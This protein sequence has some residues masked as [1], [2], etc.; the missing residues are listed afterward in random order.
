MERRNRDRGERPGASWSTWL[1]VAV[2]LAMFYVWLI[3][4]MPKPEPEPGPIGTDQDE[5]ELE[6]SPGQNQMAGF[7]LRPDHHP[8]SFIVD[9]ERLKITTAKYPDSLYARLRLAH[10]Y[11]FNNKFA[12]AEELYRE[13]IDQGKAD[14]TVMT[15]YGAC[16]LVRG[17]VEEAISILTE[18]AK[19]N[20]SYPEPQIYLA[21]AYAKRG[22]EERAKEMLGKLLTREGLPGWVRDKAEELLEQI[23]N[24][25]PEPE[26]P[27]GEEE[28]STEEQETG[29]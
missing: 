2:P 9:E 22:E 25:P 27:A 23:E 17:E 10:S 18:Q 29:G 12:E 3:S 4:P 5:A 6:E 7:I 15:R 26:A 11:F 20:P 19:G 14:P 16:L 8:L 24:P 28:G 13:I 1:L 21:W